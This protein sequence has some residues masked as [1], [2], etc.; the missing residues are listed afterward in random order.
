MAK[1]SQEFKL[2]IVR[3]YLKGTAGYTT[4]AKKHNISS[5]SVIQDWVN[6]YQLNGEDGLKHRKTKKAYTGDLKLRVIQYR[7]VNGLS[8]LQTANHFK[9]HSGS[10]V[11]NWQQLYNRGGYAALNQF[12]GRPSKLQK[13]IK[14]ALPDV[15]ATEKEELIRLREE[16]EFLK[17]SIEYEK[18][19][20]AL[21]QLRLQKTRKKQK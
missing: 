19:L 1:Y 2:K 17:M 12:S 18:K 15:E 5:K 21:V 10:M 16:N 11:S 6:S 3:E 13:Q 14:V 20:E 4:I 8:Y 9:L 7:Q